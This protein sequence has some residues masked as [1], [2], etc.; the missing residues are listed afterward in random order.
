MVLHDPVYSQSVSVDIQYTITQ[1]TANDQYLCT[2]RSV[3]LNIPGDLDRKL[4]PVADSRYGSPV[5]DSKIR[6]QKAPA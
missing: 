6:L 5:H 4:R 3:W 2:V 1:N